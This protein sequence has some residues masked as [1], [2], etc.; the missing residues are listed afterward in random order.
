MQIAACGLSFRD[1]MVS[2]TANYE[3]AD[4]ACD[5]D[6]VPHRA[7]KL[8]LDCILMN[9]RGLGGSTSSLVVERPSN[10]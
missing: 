3:I 8:R 1:Q 5:L 7:R 9:V 10:C 4:P 2:P 6:F